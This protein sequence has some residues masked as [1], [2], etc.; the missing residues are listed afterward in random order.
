MPES[1]VLILS[2]SRKTLLC[3]WFLEAAKKYG[4]GVVGADINQRAP[5]LS[6][7]D[8]F[9]DL[10]ALQAPSFMD[11]FIESVRRYQIKLVIPTRDD[12]I[13]FLSKHLSDLETNGCSILCNKDP[14]AAQMIDKESFARFCIEQMRFEDLKVVARPDDTIKNRDFPLFFRGRTDGCSLTTKVN[15]VTELKAAFALSKV[16]VATTFLKGR[17]VSIDCYVSRQGKIIYI[18]PRTRDIILGS[19]SVAT[20]TIDSSVCKSAAEEFIKESKVTGPIVFQGML[21]E[22]KFVPFEVNL[23][24]GGASVLAFRAACSGPALVIKEFILGEELTEP[25]VCKTGL[26][27]FKDFKE[28]YTF[29]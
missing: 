29:L 24:F 5:A 17:E 19:E 14:I 11:K 7:L 16:G 20:T 12:E 6:L 25:V 23:R 22:H 4:I 2:V 26:Q 15:N 3:R 9:V 8:G 13:L 10:P 1:N 21:D 18:V 27:L 28:V